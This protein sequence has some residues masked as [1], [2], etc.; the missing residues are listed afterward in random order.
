MKKIYITLIMFYIIL[1]SCNN[2][3]NNN[4]KIAILQVFENYKTAVLNDKGD[5]AYNCVDSTTIKYYTDI[6]E[7]AK[8]ADYKI[9]NSLKVLDKMTILTIR[10]YSTKEEILSFDIRNLFIYTIKKGMVGK[11]GVS[12]SSL[13]EITINGKSAIGQ[14]VADGQKAPFGFKFNNEQGKWK[15]DITSIFD[16]TAPLIEKNIRLSGLS[17]NEFIFTILENLTGKKPNSEI[18]EPLE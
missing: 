4:E 15:I 18:W 3:N 6:L 8:H 5:D 11:N 12:K 10:H 17:E 14:F 2:N 13:G 7:K 16:I 1:S 9:I